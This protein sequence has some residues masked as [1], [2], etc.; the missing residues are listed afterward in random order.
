MVKVYFSRVDDNILEINWLNR[1][2]FCL[3][4]GFN[5]KVKCDVE[6]VRILNC[7]IEEWEECEVVWE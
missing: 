1:F 2:I 6:E 5:K 3:N 4:I 7:Y